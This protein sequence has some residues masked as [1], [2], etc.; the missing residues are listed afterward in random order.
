MTNLYLSGLLELYEEPLATEDVSGNISLRSC[1]FRGALLLREVLRD[2]D[3]GEL[4][5]RLLSASSTVLSQTLSSTISSDSIFFLRR[6]IR[7][8]PFFFSC[9]RIS[10]LISY[11]TMRKN[12]WIVL[13]AIRSLRSDMIRCHQLKMQVLARVSRIDRDADPTR[14][15]INLICRAFLRAR[16][17]RAT[18][19]KIMVYPSLKSA[20]FLAMFPLTRA[21]ILTAS[22]LMMMKWEYSQKLRHVFWIL[23][24][25]R[26]DCR[27]WTICQCRQFC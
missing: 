27:S 21:W 19:C 15:C 7:F 1:L 23:V 13:A 12:P 6:F 4:L 17:I 8:M 5:L 18:D 22:K 25:A 3:L 26:C 14:T 24:A 10:L 9:R 11:F 2:L 20:L 16:N